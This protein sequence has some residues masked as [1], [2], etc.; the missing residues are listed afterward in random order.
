MTREFS[1][2]FFKI[3]FD[4]RFIFLLIVSLIAFRSPELFL[5][6]RFWAEEGTLY[7][8]SIYESS[9]FEGLFFIPRYTAEYIT[10]S[11]NIP[12][13]LAARLFP[14]EYAP[15]VSTYFS[16]L[17]LLI[18]FAIVL[19]GN[20]HLWDTPIKKLLVCLIILLAPTSTD[21]EIWLNT[22]NLQIHCGIISVCLLFEKLD[23]VSLS[24]RKRWLYRLLLIFCGLSGPY[25]MFLSLV[26]LL[27]AWHEKSRESLWFF[28]IVFLTSSVQ[29][30]LFLIINHLDM[31]SPTKIS[32]FDWIKA[33]IY[34]FNYHL[35]TPLLGLWV[36]LGAN[37]E[38]FMITGKLQGTLL[39]MVCL[40][41]I[42]TTAIV[43]YFL[44]RSRTS[45]YRLILLVAF[46]SVSLLT[47]Y[48]SMRG[49]PYGRYAVIPGILFLLL[50]LDNVR[51]SWKLDFKSLFL[52]TLLSISLVMGFTTFKAKEY[53]MA[54]IE[55]T[56]KWTDEMAQWK[57]NHDH[58]IA[59]WPF[60]WHDSSWKFYLSHRDLMQDFKERIQATDKFQLL[61]QNGEWAE[62]TIEVNGLPIDFH[63]IFIALVTGDT[64]TF[65]ADIT[66]LDEH[67]ESCGKYSISKA[68]SQRTHTILDFYSLDRRTQPHTKV[69]ERF[70][71]AKKLVF[72]LKSNTSTSLE[73]SDLKITRQKM[74][75]F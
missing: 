33:P 75:V 3:M 19:W 52:L 50:I 53:W 43:F 41:T 74:A 40:A 36:R 18:P 7:F 59:S 23:P 63:F 68:L 12:L 6:P 30:T 67:N 44:T 22:I 42:I 61:S 73:I 56:P 49:L 58:L 39:L 66:C 14:I 17:I 25:T 34:I 21:A 38:D 29:A 13:T 26:F 70:Q 16:L 8:K 27:K 57:Q 4:K 55:G 45:I 10:L 5:Y 15:A 32:Q 54:Y 71:A 9:L 24:Q 20:S 48:G 28:L 46:L 64:K 2:M 60:P 51:F 72:R 62:K 11:V 47:T 65:Q 35:M 31:V 1:K 37:V 69:I